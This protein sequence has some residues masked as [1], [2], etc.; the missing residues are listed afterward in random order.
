MRD[1]DLDAVNERPRNLKPNS[2]TPDVGTEFYGTKERGIHEQYR[3]Y[4]LSQYV[5]NEFSIGLSGKAYDMPKFDGQVP[6]SFADVQLL[7]KLMSV[8]NNG[9]AWDIGE[10]RGRA[11]EMRKKNFL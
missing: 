4:V 5:P 9:G 3:R 10:L 1:C 8:A 6:R 2:A 7:A 11:L